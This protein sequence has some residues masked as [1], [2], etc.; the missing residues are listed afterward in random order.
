MLRRADG[1][2]EDVGDALRAHGGRQVVRGHLLRRDQDSL[3]ATVGCLD[4]AVEEVGH[5]RILLRF[6]G[7]ELRPPRVRQ[8]LRHDPRHR[9][10]RKRLREGKGLVILRHRDQAGQRRPGPGVESIEPV[11]GQRPAE[12]PHPV[13]A[14]VDA[15]HPVAVPDG[16][17]RR[18][19]NLEHEWLDEFVGL[20]AGVR[21]LHRLHG[22]GFAAA[23]AADQRFIRQSGPVPAPVAV[24]RK[25]AAGQRGDLC[26]RAGQ[27]RQVGLQSP[28]DLR[29]RLRRRIPAVEKAMD[30]DAGNVVPDTQF[31]RGQEVRVDRLHAP[32]AEEAHEVKRAA[33]L[34][35]PGAEIHQRLPSKKVAAADA[36]GNP[37]EVLRHHPAGAKVQVPHLAVAHLPF[38]QAHGQAAGVEEGSRFAVPEAVPNGGPGEFDGVS[39]ALRPVAPP[40]EHD[41]DH[42]ARRAAGV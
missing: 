13:A 5:V 33:A 27:A 16:R 38:G 21:P 32:R 14:I 2:A 6:G 9:E 34:P 25:V 7:A 8:D 24:H 4:P 30:R 15:E 1:A 17:R 28:H 23:R 19:V 12:L 3:L 31:H 42:L 41:E 22:V 29:S 39:F 40:V 36:C 35:E 26:A 37:D 20:A 18:A 10:W 11:H